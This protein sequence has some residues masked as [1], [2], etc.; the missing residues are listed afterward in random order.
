MPLGRFLQLVTGEWDEINDVLNR[1]FI[2]QKNRV[3]QP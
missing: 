2:E 1:I 3:I